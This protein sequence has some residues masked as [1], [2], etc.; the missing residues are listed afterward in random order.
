[1]HRL[2]L[3]GCGGMAKGHARRFSEVHDRMR[4]V[5]AVDPVLDRA[6]AVADIMGG[7]IRVTGDYRQVLDEC[8]SVLLVLPHHLHHPIAKAC[9]EAGKHVLLEKPMC[10]TEDQCL[11]LIAT[12]E[13]HGRI[14]MIAYPM[15][16]HPLLVRMKELIDAKTYG[17]CFQLAIWTEQFTRYPEGHWATE[18]KKLGGGQL[19][20][21]G[22]HYIDLLL[23]FLGEPES[24][25][26]IGTNFGTPWMQRE[27]SSNVVMK[28]RS[29]AMG[30]HFGTWGARGTRL[31][32]AFH[33]H[34]TRGMLEIDRARGQ[35][36]V[37][38]DPRTDAF[39]GENRDHE[40][41]RDKGAR[42]QVLLEADLSKHTELELGH[43]LDCIQTGRRPA[44]DGHDSLQGLR[45]I[46]R[47]YDAEAKGRMADLRGLGLRRP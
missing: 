37:H 6:Q 30:Y 42:E 20:S 31:R 39:D 4:L 47:L 44:T 9:L 27:G 23:W 1:M 41:F 34:C 26:H 28:F 18:A 7:G 45:V 32:Y 22:C 5:A 12:A 43:F 40:E 46:W 19:F 17:E 25:S 8:D 2:A 3:V 21:H 14:L 33:A 15:R 29:G 16:Y 13:R 24:G 36:I 38:R 10:N 11:D 35:L